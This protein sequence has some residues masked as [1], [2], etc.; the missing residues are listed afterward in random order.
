M[1]KR[2]KARPKV[3][4]RE[5]ADKA[6][7]D[8]GV[9]RADR[10]AMRERREKLTAD[11]IAGMVAKGMTADEMLAASVKRSEQF[12]ALHRALDEII[13]AQDRLFLKSVRETDALMERI[14]K[15]SAG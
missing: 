15:G 7:E 6:L 14:R 12:A 5:I 3:D 2:L 9:S 11:W 1:A 4:I 8:I 10:E 13:A